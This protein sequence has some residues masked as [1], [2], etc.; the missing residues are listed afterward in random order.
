MG[1][2]SKVFGGGRSRVAPYSL[3]SD[4]AQQLDALEARGADVTAPRESEFFLSFTSEPKVRLAVDEL[5]AM[6]ITHELVEPSHDIP[7]WMVFVR[8]FNKPLVPDYLRETIDLCERIADQYGGEYEGWAG[9][10]TDEEKG[11]SDAL[12]VLR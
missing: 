3:W 6:R 5:R 11:D 4:D 1:F 12:D 2:L 8:G 10:L 7:E 9:L